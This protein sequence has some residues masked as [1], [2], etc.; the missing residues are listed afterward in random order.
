MGENPERRRAVQRQAAG[1]QCASMHW[2]VKPPGIA[3]KRTAG[4]G[5]KHVCNGV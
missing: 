4:G 2:C 1:T 5:E 3:G